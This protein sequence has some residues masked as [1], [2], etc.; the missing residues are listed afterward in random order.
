MAKELCRPIAS[1]SRAS[2]NLGVVVGFDKDV[3]FGSHRDAW[4]DGIFADRVPEASAFAASLAAH[5]G[6]LDAP[7]E[8]PVGKNVLV[9]HGHG[10]IGKSELSRRLA[11]WVAGSLEP[12]IEWGPPP[13]TRVA[14]TARIDLHGSEGRIDGARQIASLRIQLGLL[15]P[16]WP[17]FDVAFAAYWAQTHPMDPLPVGSEGGEDNGFADATLGSLAALADGHGWLAEDAGTSAALSVAGPWLVRRLGRAIAQL[18]PSK[19]GVNAPRGYDEFFHRCSTVPSEDDPRPDILA[20]LAQLL[21]Y[22]LALEPEQPLVVVFIDTFERLSLDARRAGESLLNRVAYAMANVLFVITGRNHLTWSDAQGHA[23][24]H[25][26][27]EAW[28]LLATGV[29]QEPHQHALK[30][31]SPE[32]TMSVLRGIRERLSIDISDGDLETLARTSGG[33][34]EHLRLIGHALAARRDQGEPVSAA[35]LPESFDDLV[36]LLLEDVPNEAERRAIRAA[37]LVPS[38][39]AA[40]VA[41]AANVD[42]GDAERALRRPLFES[43]TPGESRMHDKVRAALR[44]S[45]TAVEGG[46]STADWER[47]GTRALVH[48]QDVRARIVSQYQ[49]ASDEIASSAATES[50]L[51]TIGNAISIV[52]EVDAQVAPPAA[53]ADSAPSAYSDWVSEAIVK[54]PSVSGLRPHTPARSATRYGGDILAFIDAKGSELPLPAR[55][56]TLERLREESPQL[57]RIAGRHLSYALTNAGRWDEAVAAM[58]ELL[59]RRPNDAFVQYQRLVRLAIARRFVQVTAGM[60]VLQPGRR[61]RMETRMDFFGRGK[62]EKFVATLAARAQE[63]RQLGLLKDSLESEG[64]VARW[65]GLV[66]PGDH[67]WVAADLRLRAEAAGHDVALRDALL[68]EVMATG[69]F[70]EDARR[71]IAID[72][73]RSDGEIGVREALARAADAFAA[74]DAD[75]LEELSAEISLSPVP[76]NYSWIPIEFLFEDVGHPLPV[77]PT[78]WLADREVNL[79]RWSRRWERWREHVTR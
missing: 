61:E 35:E 12:A 15:R 59:V 26:G 36:L 24:P 13:A 64:I 54:G 11:D 41:A 53:K 7:Y 67:C 51:R 32:D 8:S 33:L 17:L 65:A 22:E 71:L 63:E 27:S 34:P 21:S 72:R 44:G 56:E 52:C 68:S 31:L 16:S 73:A 57:G 66:F 30:Y 76:R 46:W 37:A 49:D 58:D 29:E 39:T 25:R 38:C 48:L 47:A 28:P 55:L 62:P 60:D 69:H 45:G 4:S 9:F 1:L 43:F 40:L 50:L 78:E 77:T 79:K 19:L 75:A 20:Q 18:F 2:L 10:G 70:T 3:D 14:A 42:E 23:L 74:D 6:R 5:R